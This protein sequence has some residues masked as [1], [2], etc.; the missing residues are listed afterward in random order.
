MGIRI[1][2]GLMILLKLFAMLSRGVALSRRDTPPA[3]A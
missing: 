3:C 2:T 1:E